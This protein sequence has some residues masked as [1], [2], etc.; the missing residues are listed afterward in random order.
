MENENKKK[1]KKKL[2]TGIHLPLWIYIRNSKIYANLKFGLI[3][4]FKIKSI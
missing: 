3:L 1:N 4:A 2:I